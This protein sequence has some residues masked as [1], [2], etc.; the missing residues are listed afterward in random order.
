MTERYV[1]Y[2]YPKSVIGYAVFLYHRF[3]LSLRDV[4]E[5]LAERGIIV[6]YETIRLWCKNLAHQFTKRLKKKLPCRGDKVHIDE[7]RVSINGEVYWLWRAVDKDGDEIDILLQKRR[8]AKAARRFFKRLLLKLEKAPRILVTDKLRSYKKARRILLPNT[9][10]RSHKRLNNRIENSYQ[11]TREKERQMRKFKQPGSAQRFLS[12]MGIILNLFKV[13][14][15]K[16]Q[17]SVYRQKLQ[18]A[19]TVWNEL[20]ASQHPCA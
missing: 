10:H 2:R 9:E 15:Y 5:L 7:V 18:Q 20:V 3:R 1:G 6:T 4:S 19:F 14:R 17:A 8:N 11:P 13:G 12:S 16:H